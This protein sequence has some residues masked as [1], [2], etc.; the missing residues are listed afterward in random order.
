MTFKRFAAILQIFLCSIVPKAMGQWTYSSPTATGDCA[1]LP[2]NL[3]SGFTVEPVVSRQLFQSVNPTRIAKMAFHL[4]AASGKTD[5]YITEK[6]SSSQAGRVLYYNGTA[7]TLTVIGTI[8]NVYTGF[9]EAG[10][11]GITLNPK[12][13]AQDNYLYI[14]YVY[15]NSANASN[16]NGWRVSRFKL[17]PSTKMLD[18]SSEKVIILIPAGSAGR[19]HTGGSLHFD[20][21]GNLYISTGDNE[22]LANGPAN[23][24]DLR[25]GILRIK[26]DESEKGYSIP[27]GN[28]GEYWASQWESQGNTARAAAYRNPAIVK[29]E[30]YIKGSRNPYSF[31]V[32]PNRLG[33]VEW[34]ECGP[35]KET[36]EEHN[37]S[38][39][40]AFSGWPF[41]AADVRQAAFATDYNEPN[42][43]SAQSAWDAFNPPGMSKQA[44]VNNWANAAGYDTLPPMHTPIYGTS[45]RSCSQGGPIIRYDGSINNPGK[46][47]P[48]LDNTVMYTDF[49]TSNIWAVKLN[50]ATGA[51][52]G[53]HTTVFTATGAPFRTNAA[54]SLQNPIDFQQGADGNLYLVSWGAGCCDGN[55]A[56]N[57][58]EGIVRIK[59]TGT[60]QDPNLSPES[61]SQ[62]R[63]A[64]AFKERYKWDGKLLSVREDG[65]HT[66]RILDVDGRTLY[67]ADS[68]N[69]KEYA[70]RRLL[71][72]R[73]GYFVV[74]IS[75]AKG[76]FSKGIP[77]F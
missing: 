73:T 72:G 55:R 24:A 54:P 27:E 8:P 18:I 56:P 52:I 34:S 59:Y 51:A 38:T 5:I 76:T 40:P 43:P 63:S 33:W 41:W 28:F 19:W 36:G 60:C 46:M 25:G 69:G 75:N 4:N 13:F 53:S 42:E 21:F 17:N 2:Q 22:S 64:E 15:G 49:N 11:L 77:V 74:N 65:R 71:Q 37:V 62:I 44:P 45:A 7:N 31:S 12:T 10:Q 20:N 66:I 58:A 9:N 61:P 6:G 67:S 57:A 26:P 35:D 1:S 32:D 48:H 68:E 14:M 3:S 29:P 23:T 47:P 16:S 50:P 39:K 30:L 70:L